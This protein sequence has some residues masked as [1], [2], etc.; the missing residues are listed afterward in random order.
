MV[1]KILK[2]DLP[3]WGKKKKNIGNHKTKN[4]L[5]LKYLTLKKFFLLN[6]NTEIVLYILKKKKVIEILL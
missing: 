4:A 2:S 1:I 6:Q 3:P 5:K